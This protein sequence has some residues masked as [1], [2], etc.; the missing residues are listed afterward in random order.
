MNILVE[1]SGDSGKR[2]PSCSPKPFIREMKVQCGLVRYDLT[3]VQT[4]SSLVRHLPVLLFK[5]EELG[6]Q[7]RLLFEKGGVF[8]RDTPCH[9]LELPSREG[10]DY[11]REEA[12]LSRCEKWRYSLQSPCPLTARRFEGWDLLLLYMRLQY[13]LH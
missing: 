8:I 11:P 6:E 5:H 9:S 4:F 3:N 13:I 2:K 1:I 10:E 12:K 7:G